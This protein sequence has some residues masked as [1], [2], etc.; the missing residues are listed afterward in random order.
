MKA[1]RLLVCDGG[2]SRRIKRRHKMM[3][4]R[5]AA[6]AWKAEVTWRCKQSVLHTSGW[7]WLEAIADQWQSLAILSL[8]LRSKCVGCLYTA[9]NNS[10]ICQDFFQSFLLIRQFTQD[11]GMS[12]MCECEYL[13]MWV[14]GLIGLVISGL[15]GVCV[16]PVIISVS[17]HYW[18]QYV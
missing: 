12:V 2:W 9:S 8:C 16:G 18:F 5:S 7:F 17:V 6:L 15:C 14:C 4:G 13:G 11:V 1:S 10:F 3:K